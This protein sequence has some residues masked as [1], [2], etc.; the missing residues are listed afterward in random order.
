MSFRINNKIYFIHAIRNVDINIE[1]AT[2]CTM[3]GVFVTHKTPSI[4]INYLDK[5]KSEIIHLWYNEDPEIL[6]ETNEHIRHAK[7]QQRAEKFAHD[8]V[9][10]LFDVKNVYN[11]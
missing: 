7:S 9:D 4:T 8:I 1:N 10:K 2:L 5:K 11:K 6:K 3:N